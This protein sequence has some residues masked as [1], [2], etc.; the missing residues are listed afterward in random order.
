VNP[1]AAT[2]TGTT[3][4][5]NITNGSG[6][7]AL[8]LPQNIHTG[9]N[10]TFTSQILSSTT[11]QIVLETT[12]TTTISA[13]APSSSITLTLPNSSLDTLVRQSTSATLTNKTLSSLTINLV[14]VTGNVLQGNVSNQTLSTTWSGPFSVTSRN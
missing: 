11:N 14:S 4:Q 10:P 12:N 6:S 7:I 1:L 2:L 5:I 9:A 13:P 3:N 8:A